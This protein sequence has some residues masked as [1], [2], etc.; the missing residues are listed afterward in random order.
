[1]ARDTLTD[2]QWEH[3]RPVLPPQKPVT[4]RRAIDHRLI[5]NAI[6]W[7]LRTGAPWRDLPAE[8]GPWQTAATRFY[9]WVKGGIWDRILAALQQ[10]ADDDG[11][12][13]WS[14]HH[15]DGSTVRAHQHAAGARWL[16]GQAAN[17]PA[18]DALGRSRGGFTTKL[19]VRVDRGGKPLVLLV[20]AG[21]RH[22]QS[23]F[24]ALME[25]GAV[26]RAGRGRPRVRPDRV[27]GDR[28]YSSRTVRRYLR[29]RGIRA[30]IPTRNNEQRSPTFDCAAYRE[31]NAVERLINRLKQF[32]RIATRYEKRVA[33]YLAML[34][35]A[36]ILLW[37]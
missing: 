14:L 32:R 29:R 18:G 34:T 24:T 30:V 36:A 8:Y 35:L 27:A 21:E 12:L 11:D 33:N 17:D 37:L 28:A 25:R 1:M 9:R 13:D 2:R 5:L 6:L 7:V 16:A 26:K 31:R 23:V 3:L 19:H 15:V 22:E 4:G 10:Q 20:T